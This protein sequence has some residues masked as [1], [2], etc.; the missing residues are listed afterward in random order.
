[1][2]TQPPP[3]S[4]WRHGTIYNITIMR[5]APYLVTDAR[6]QLLRE[7]SYM[8]ATS[9]HRRS[10]HPGADP[11]AI[12]EL[13][14]GSCDAKRAA[15]DSLLRFNGRTGRRPQL[16]HHHCCA[17]APHLKSLELRLDDPTARSPTPNSLRSPCAHDL[18]IRPT[19]SN[20][21]P[22]STRP[23]ALRPSTNENYTIAHDVK[24]VY[25]VCAARVTLFEHRAP[26]IGG[27]L[28]SCIMHH[29]SC[30][31]HHASCIMHHA[32]CITHHVASKQ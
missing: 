16:A 9:R 7:E 30:I 32:S 20:S 4:A 28:A 12:A 18:S 26:C 17:V 10:P 29:A 15:S 31:M 24:V 21:E 25:A 19:R 23:Y 27:R 13:P 5:L 1:L 14:C 6:A 8:L 2:Q 3:P 22:S 11:C